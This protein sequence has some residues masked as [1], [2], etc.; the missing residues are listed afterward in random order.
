MAQENVAISYSLKIPVQNGQVQ[1]S[2]EEQII[3]LINR[4][5]FAPTDSIRKLH[6]WLDEQCKYK[7]LGIVT[8]RQGAGKS[9][10]LKVYKNL[11]ADRKL[12]RIPLYSLYLEVLP[13]WTIRDICTRILK[14]LNHGDRKGN[15]ENLLTRT[16][17]A[18]IKFGVETLIVDHAD[19]LTRK[20]LLGLIRLSLMKE[21]RISLILAG[22]TELESRLQK[23]DL[24]G[25]FEKI[26]QF[27][28]L[29]EGDFSDVLLE[30]FAKDFLPSSASGTLF[31]KGI[32][33][34]LFLAS[35]YADAEE[36][37]FRH[38]MNILVRVIVQSSEGQ[39]SLCISKQ[40]L[41][42]VATT[43]GAS[44]RVLPELLEELA[45]AIA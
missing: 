3:R 5:F 12:R 6:D 7:A 9:I 32:M 27:D 25:Y 13:T 34:N 14:L 10:G 15:S 28:A 21:T 33:E 2:V 41:L 38:L 39:S 16:W 35:K 37:S 40:V 11:N 30:H 36:C 43:Y 18:L 29:S 1:L 22:S 20:A 44:D 26:H 31:D 19:E 24:D 45:D 4:D 42:S 23:K 8:G 17:E